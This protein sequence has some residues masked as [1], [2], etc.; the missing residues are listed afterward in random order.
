MDEIWKC[1]NVVCDGDA[2]L[3]CIVDGE[4]GIVQRVS[5]FD[6][7]DGQY[8]ITPTQERQTLETNEKVCI[9]DIIIKPI[10]ENYGLI[11]WN[12]HSLKVS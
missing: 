8:E 2:E 4:S 7:Y 11:T 3:N 1:C 10:P 5:S 12:G 9:S 6:A